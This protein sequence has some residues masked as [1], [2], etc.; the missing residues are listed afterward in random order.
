MVVIEFQEVTAGTVRTATSMR[1]PGEGPTPQ[2]V[3]L[4]TLVQR[5]LEQAEAR[6]NENAITNS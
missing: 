6:M 5:L 2:L 1:R 4:G 3:H